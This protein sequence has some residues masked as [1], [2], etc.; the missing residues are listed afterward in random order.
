MLQLRP[1]PLFCLY[2]LLLFTPWILLVFDQLVLD[3]VSFE[4]SFLI[5]QPLPSNVIMRMYINTSLLSLKSTENLQHCLHLTTKQIIYCDKVQSNYT[6]MKA[7]SYIAL[8]SAAPIVGYFDTALHSAAPVVGYFD[9]ALSSATPIVGYFELTL[10]SDA[11]AVGYFS[12]ALLSAA[13]VVKQSDLS[14]LLYRSSVFILNSINSLVWVLR[15]LYIQ[16]SYIIVRVLH[17]MFVILK[18]I[19]VIGIN[20]SKWAS[21]STRQLWDIIH[22]FPYFIESPL[23]NTLKIAITLRQNIMSKH[24]YAIYI[25]KNIQSLT[26]FNVI[27]ALRLW[28]ICRL[29]ISSVKRHHFNIRPTI[30]IPMIAISSKLQLNSTHPALTQEN[31]LIGG[32]GSIQ[33]SG[34]SLA[35]YIVNDSFKHFAS[36]SNFCFVEHVHKSSLSSQSDLAFCKMPLDILVPQLPSAIQKN[37]LK[38]HDIFIPARANK[39]NRI[40][41][42][43]NHKGACC[44]TYLSVF[45]P[46][47]SAAEQQSLKTKN[48]EKKRKN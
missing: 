42:L 12:I 46:L 2:Q 23:S 30:L 26:Y 43:T 24:D 19:K 15:V 27:D 10:L 45:K 29:P 3:I 48:T 20:Y 7:C 28:S 9:T 36:I 33:F 14:T 17:Y 47:Q 5:Q 41:L 22:R 44:D 16:S 38:Q 18:L 32:G 6:L 40:N 1:Y 4:G 37:I 39:S 31:I 35:P 21:I 8:A 25:V 13:P 34:D 11:P